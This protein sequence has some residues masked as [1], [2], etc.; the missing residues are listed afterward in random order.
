M[1]MEQTKCSETSAHKI[2]TPENN[3][4][5]SIQHLEHGEILKSRIIS[6]FSSFDASADIYTVTR[7]RH[8][9]YVFLYM[10]I[11]DLQALS[12]TVGSYC[13]FL[14][15]FPVAGHTFRA[16]INLSYTFCSSPNCYRKHFTAKPSNVYIE[17]D[18]PLH[19]N[20]MSL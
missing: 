8:Y 13:S 17:A 4:E 20:K 11:V 6:Y 3:P 14:V 18:K 7:D 12:S 1:K 10:K 5:E 16:S 19:Y 9:I 2:Q 15:T